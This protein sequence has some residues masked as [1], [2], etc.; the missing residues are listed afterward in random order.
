MSTRLRPA[1]IVAVALAVVC[2]YCGTEQ[3]EPTTGSEVWEPEDIIAMCGKRTCV[4]CDETMLL[5]SR[6]IARVEVALATTR[7]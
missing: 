5:H 7:G 1:Q 4:S 6:S 2:P 3:P